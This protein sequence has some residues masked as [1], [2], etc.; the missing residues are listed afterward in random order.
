VS[1]SISPRHSLRL[2]ENWFPTRGLEIKSVAFAPYQQFLLLG[3]PQNSVIAPHSRL[4]E[5]G[6]GKHPTP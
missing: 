2:F 3:N 6:V 5:K 1:I 4:E